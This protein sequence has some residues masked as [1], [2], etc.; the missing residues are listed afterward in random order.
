MQARIIC[1]VLQVIVFGI[2]AGIRYI[3]FQ[4][5]GQKKAYDDLITPKSQ[6]KWNVLV[7]LIL[8]CIILYIALQFKAPY[9]DYK[10][11][12]YNYKY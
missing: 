4:I 5:I 11:L 6:D 3:F 9:Q 2:G 10:Y 7:G 8:A 12:P 1:F